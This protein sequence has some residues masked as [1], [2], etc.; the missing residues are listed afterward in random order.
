MLH[1]IA[2]AR[3][4]A[5]RAECQKNLTQIWLG[6][7]NYAKEHNAEWPKSLGELYPKYITEPSVF[8]CPKSDDTVGSS[9][10][11]DSWSSYEIVYAGKAISDKDIVVLQDKNDHA[12]RPGGRNYLFADG[13]VKYRPTE[14]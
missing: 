3:E 11:I 5:L 6:I 2:E 9:H 4:M 10:G 1:G 13:Q 8:M 12:H 14:N 7:E